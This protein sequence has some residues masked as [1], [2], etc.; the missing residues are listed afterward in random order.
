MVS[1]IIMAD[2]IN[3]N[4]ASL[5]ELIQIKNIGPKRAAIIIKTRE[6]KGNLT[7]EDLKLLEGIP[8]TIWDPLIENGDITVDA[9]DQFDKEQHSEK[10]AES[11]QEQIYKMSEILKQRTQEN[12]MFQQQIAEMQQYYEKSVTEQEAR[13][14]KQI[15][16]VQE[17]SKDEVDTMKAEYKNREEQLR[18]EIKKRDD[19]IKQMEEIRLTSEKIEKL[20]PSGIYTSRFDPSLDSK[21]NIHPYK[22]RKL[23]LS[24]L[25][26]KDCENTEKRTGGPPAPK[27]STYDGKTDWRP[28]FIQ[29]S[30]IADKYKWTPQERLD[31][32]LQS[33]RDKA[34][35]F[36]S[37]K[38][39]SGKGN[40]EQVCN[41][42]NERFGRK[43]LPHIIRRQLQ[44]LK[45][46]QDELLEEYAERAQ[47]MSTDGYPDT[48]EEFVEIIAIDA[49]LKGCTDKKA[50]LTAMDKNPATLDQALQFV[51]SANA[52]QR[53]I[54]GPKRMDLK[55]VMFEDEVDEVNSGNDPVIRAVKFTD[56]DNSQIT[57]FEQRLKKTEEGLE[58]TRTMVKDILKI[59]SRSRSKS[60]VRQVTSSPIRSRTG[61]DRDAN[62]DYECFRCGELGHFAR[63]C[64]NQQR[65]L[66]PYRN[67]SRSPSPRR[68]LNTNG[69]RI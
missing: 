28:Y 49:F 20:T 64:P 68:E 30:H 50:A 57:K 37:I 2:P 52:N 6:E 69:L 56:R 4:K 12:K 39:K 34:L 55:R 29:F 25:A 47:E 13:F 43:D 62:R 26:S 40:Y 18:E 16:E 45:Q 58:E 66:S 31:R 10:Q 48:P 11:L 53:V 8:N 5:E 41:K 51:K 19:R 33:L 15:F 17:A 3:I 35:K 27:L 61:N 23:S 59:V 63:D 9:Q 60:P 42:M 14:R 38:N 44:D 7:L 54:L 65:N 22:D 24:S 46:E 21:A 32:L 1:L 36:F 67:R